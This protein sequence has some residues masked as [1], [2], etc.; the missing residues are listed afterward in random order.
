MGNLSHLQ[1]QQLCVA[2]HIVYNF[3]CFAANDIVGSQAATGN[4]AGCPWQQL[5]FHF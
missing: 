3:A 1:Y 5:D 4:G 2:Y